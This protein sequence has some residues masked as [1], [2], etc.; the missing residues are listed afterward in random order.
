MFDN[1]IY[2]MVGLLVVSLV[3]VIGGVLA[4]KYNWD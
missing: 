3:F 1:T 4:N 2:M